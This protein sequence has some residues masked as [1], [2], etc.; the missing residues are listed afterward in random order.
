MRRQS[1]QSIHYRVYSDGSFNEFTNT[2]LES[3]E[4][5]TLVTRESSDDTSA[6]TLHSFPHLRNLRSEHVL[7]LKLTDIPFDRSGGTVTYHDTDVIALRPFSGLFESSVSFTFGIDKRMATS[8]SFIELIRKIGKYPIAALLN[9]GVIQIKG[10]ELDLDYAE[11]LLR[12]N[13]FLSGTPHLREQ[14]I[15]S[16]LAA[17]RP[18]GFHQ[19][20]EPSLQI[21]TPRLDLRSDD[22]ALAHFTRP[23]RSRIREIDDLD[24]LSNQRIRLERTP[25]LRAT[26]LDILYDR[27][28]FRVGLTDDLKS[29]R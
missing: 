22:L 24:R 11:F 13:F 8:A 7:L 23:V 25:G 9:T 20:S 15:W 10:E 28:R 2:P 29:T 4:N 17:R 16:L 12:N 27:V 18:D 14:T 5:I 19:L 21:V 6:K 1:A 26:K 3:F